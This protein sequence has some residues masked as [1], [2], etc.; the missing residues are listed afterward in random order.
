IR[1]LKVQQHGYRR[2]SSMK[3]SRI[4]IAAAFLLVA[5]CVVTN[6]RKTA[7]WIHDQPAV[8]SRLDLML[9]QGKPVNLAL[10]ASVETAD[11]R[12]DYRERG[13]DIDQWKRTIQEDLIAR[14]EQA[15]FSRLSMHPG[16]RILDR[17]ATEKIMQE[18]HFET[19]GT[20]PE[21][22]RIRLGQMLGAN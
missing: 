9:R 20:V 16:F 12:D 19:S 22:L 6:T 7:W 2:P 10:I 3:T 13:L 5:G 21:S 15:L 11:Q 4:F 1:A 14:S 8:V 17:N 18:M